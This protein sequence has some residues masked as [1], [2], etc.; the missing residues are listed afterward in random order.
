MQMYPNKGVAE[1]KEGAK[2]AVYD[3]ATGMVMWVN[4]LNAGTLQR[5]HA[6]QFQKTLV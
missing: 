6:N 3:R 5:A 2:D 1:K 4:G